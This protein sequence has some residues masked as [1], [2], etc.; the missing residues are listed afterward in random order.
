MLVER[1]SFIVYREGY[2]RSAYQPDWE[3]FLEEA[4]KRIKANPAEFEEILRLTVGM[5]GGDE[6]IHR[7]RRSDSDKTIYLKHSEYH[8][9]LISA[10]RIYIYR[11]PH[12]WGDY[13]YYVRHINL[14]KEAL[15]EVSI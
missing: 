13:N 4:K 5:P 8:L 6:I 1:G 7:E 11:Y 12:H 10:E 14:L 9:D 3:P 2:S 15:K